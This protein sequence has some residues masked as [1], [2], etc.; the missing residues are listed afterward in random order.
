MDAHRSGA[1]EWRCVRRAAG[2]LEARLHAD[3]DHARDADDPG[4]G[5]TPPPL[6]LSPVAGSGNRGEKQRLPEQV[7][8]VEAQLLDRLPNVVEGEMRVPLFRRLRS[9]GVPATDQLLHRA[10]VE[11]AVVEIRLQARH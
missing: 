9:V 5:L 1:V 3:G 6:Y 8:A 7:P 11:V 4:S 2:G 10:D